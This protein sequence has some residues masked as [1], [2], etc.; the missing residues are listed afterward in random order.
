[1]YQPQ[2][3]KPKAFLSELQI[4][5]YSSYE[6][7]DYRYFT[8]YRTQQ[9]QQYGAEQK[10]GFKNLVCCALCLQLSNLKNQYSHVS[11]VSNVLMR[12]GR[13]EIKMERKFDSELMHFGTVKDE[14]WLVLS[15]YLCLMTTLPM[16][17]THLHIVPRG[18][19]DAF[20]TTI[21]FIFFWFRQTHV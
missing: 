11:L 4:L 5:C 18:I 12:C 1:M 17:Q 16:L 2:K 10:Y 8:S 19:R 7:V 21:W 15:V 20:D 13:F 14:C 6:I 3:Q 9:H